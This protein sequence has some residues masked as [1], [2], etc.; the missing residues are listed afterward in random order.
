MQARV[1]RWMLAAVALLIVAVALGATGIA[2]TSA[3]S[4]AFSVTLEQNPDQIDAASDALVRAGGAL[5]VLLT[6]ALVLGALAIATAVVGLVVAVRGR[7]HARSS[8]GL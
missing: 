4:N 7:A 2:I 1:R 3:A 8:A 5:D 6:E